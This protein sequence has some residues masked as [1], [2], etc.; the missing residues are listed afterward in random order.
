MRK[1]KCNSYD[2]NL[3]NALKKIPIPI[4]DKKHNLMIFLENDQARSNQD[5][6]SHIV[7]K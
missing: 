5:R 1:K 6:Y 3:I 4:I 2:Q 7:K